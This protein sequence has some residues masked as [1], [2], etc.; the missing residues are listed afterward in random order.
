[1]RVR[2][3]L[4]LAT[5]VTVALST[6]SCATPGNPSWAVEACDTHASWASS[7][8]PEEHQARAGRVLTR[9]IPDGE[10][11]AVALA[12]RAFAD[13]ASQGD[14]AAVLVADGDLDFACDEIGWE[15]SEG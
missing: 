13:A 4:A 1:M 3:A 8:K 12:A 7:G 6:S 9:D 11:S 5:A 10:G 15:P 14:R 2:K